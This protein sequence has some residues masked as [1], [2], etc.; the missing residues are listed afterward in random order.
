MH[1]EICSHSARSGLIT[2]DTVKRGLQLCLLQL[3]LSE[4]RC[5]CFLF[6]P[7][8]PFPGTRLVTRGAAVAREVPQWSGCTLTRCHSAL[9]DLCLTPACCAACGAPGG[10][11]EAYYPCNTA[12]V[13]LFQHKNSVARSGKEFYLLYLLLPSLLPLKQIILFISFVFLFVCV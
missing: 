3:A 12:E 11:A 9:P 4:S 2:S 1:L 10:A 8:S 5:D 13:W 6:L 7:L